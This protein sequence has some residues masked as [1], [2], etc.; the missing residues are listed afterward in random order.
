MPSK[1]DDNYLYQLFLR[2][3]SVRFTLTR[4][5]QISQQ[6]VLSRYLGGSLVAS[7]LEVRILRCSSIEFDMMRMM[8][9]TLSL[10][11]SMIVLKSI[12]FLR[13]S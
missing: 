8:K 5:F 9:A 4:W 13:E 2:T 10:L 7:L 6:E 11:F 1:A 3:S 12:H